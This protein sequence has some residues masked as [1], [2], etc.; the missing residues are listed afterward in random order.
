MRYIVTILAAL[1]LFSCSVKKRTYRDGYYIDWISKGKN[2]LEKFSLPNG[3]A[4]VNSIL[5]AEGITVSSKN[6][7]VAQIP[8][9]RLIFSSDTCGD[10]ITFK[11]GDQVLARV[12]EITEDK[13]KYKR[14]DNL[15]GPIFVVNKATVLNIR[16]PNGVVEKI[17][18]STEPEYTPKTNSS[19]KDKD[20]FYSEQKV[21]PLAGWA[22]VAWLIG[23][24]T[25]TL[26]YIAALILSNK[27]IKDITLQPKK[28][29]G[30]QLAQVVR[31]LSLV[32]LTLAL[33]GLII[34]IAA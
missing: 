21:H 4:P 31:G 29:R 6:D 18:A 9:L 25:L 7:P 14:C 30:M 13:I 33:L 16:Y 8:S 32:C 19:P 22:L 24:P 23:A 2:T 12:A 26:G 34:L 11:S 1:L 5:H 10:L 20:A 17:E 27:A 3:V 15:E 28:W